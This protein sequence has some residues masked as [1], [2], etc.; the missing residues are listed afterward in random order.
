MVDGAITYRDVALVE[1]QLGLPPRQTPCVSVSELRARIYHSDDCW[2]V[3]PVASV[4]WAWQYD[5]ASMAVDNGTTIL[6]PDN[7]VVTDPG[8]WLRRA[9]YSSTHTVS[10]TDTYAE[11]ISK[12][13]A[14]LG[15]SGEGFLEFVDGGDWPL[16]APFEG[17]LS[18]GSWD[19]VDWET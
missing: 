5:A 3:C 16:G 1:Y 12:L 6:R 18:D 14:A 7:V 17:T 10:P 11:A 15:C 9:V 8:R 4:A 2:C 13:D 19:P